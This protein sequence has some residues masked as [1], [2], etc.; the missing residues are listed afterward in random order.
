MGRPPR[1][2]LAARH[3]V[4]IDSTMHFHTFDRRLL[5]C[6]RTRTAWRK[7]NAQIG[8]DERDQIPFGGQLVAAI[9]VETMAANECRGLFR[10]FAIG[11]AQ[12]HLLAPAL[13]VD[14]GLRADAVLGPE[15]HADFSRE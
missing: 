12:P 10:K 1:R 8:F 14:G 4:E 2:S 3:A 11:A 6:P 7:C 13:D 5:Q 9:D 15:P